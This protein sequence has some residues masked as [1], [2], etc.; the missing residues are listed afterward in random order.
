MKISTNWINDYVDIK[1]MDKKELAL[2]ITNAGVNIETVNEYKFNNLVVGEIIEC[3]K[4]PGSDH[5][6]ICIVN[7]GKEKPQQI[8]CGA[9]N[10]R[11][12]IKV[13][14]AMPGAVLP[15]DFKIEELS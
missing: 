10:V 2:K 13:I 11:V 7:V 8:I 6:N 14:V 5:L 12:G 3:E 15:G 4:H 1:E 9:D